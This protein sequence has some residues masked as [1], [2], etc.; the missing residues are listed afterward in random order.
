MAVQQQQQHVLMAKADRLQASCVRGQWGEGADLSLPQH[1]WDPTRVRCPVR[2]AW[3]RRGPG[4]GA[5][6]PERVVDPSSLRA[7]G[8]DGAGPFSEGQ[9]GRGPRQGQ[10]GCPVG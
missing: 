2:A 1:C 8:E 10:E 3:D 7:C 4:R 6:R 9:D 5:V